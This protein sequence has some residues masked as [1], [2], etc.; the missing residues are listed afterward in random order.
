MQDS[1]KIISQIARSE[2]IRAMC[3]KEVQVA[4]DVTRDHL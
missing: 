2:L 3:G 1:H 4:G